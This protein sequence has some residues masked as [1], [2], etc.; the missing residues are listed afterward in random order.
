M[1]SWCLASSS[2]GNC[3]V[4][5]FSNE[6]SNYKQTI[7]LEAGIPWPDMEKKAI[8]T[9]CDDFLDTTA[10]LITHGHTDHAKAIKQVMNAGIDVYA[11][12][13][14]HKQ[15][16]TLEKGGKVISDGSTNC[17]AP[18]LYVYSFKVQHDYEESL[19]FIIS[20]KA[21]G[22]NVLFINDCKYYTQ[23]LSAFK[24]DYIFME[25]NY[26]DKYTYTIYNQAVKEEDHIKIAQYKRVIDSHM[27]LSTTKK[28]LA[29]LN[30]ERTKAIFLMH[31]SDRNANEYKMKSQVAEV[32]KK[33][34]LVC[35]KN[36]GVK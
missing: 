10:C 36:G 8:M 9:K 26:E 20:C 29:K 4:V 35:Q 6:Q 33:L 12:K 28:S 16:G 24:F 21:T 30:L 17:I 14:T 34:V 32:T 5:Q 22:E 2:S 31:L 18:Q 23:D 13:A 15:Y 7:M 3:I 19:G 25:C 1:K 11:S 27:A